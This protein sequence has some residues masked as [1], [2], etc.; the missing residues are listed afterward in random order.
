MPPQMIVARER[1]LD[2]LE[3][4]AQTDAAVRAN[5]ALARLGPAATVAALNHLA[6]IGAVD[7]FYLVAEGYY[8]NR[9][10]FGGVVG[11]T[12]SDPSITDQH[13]RITQLLFTPNM[14]CVRTDT[15]FARL[16]DEVGL[17]EYWTQ[18]GLEPDYRNASR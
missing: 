17:T 18:T 12:A 10:P 15:R 16:C 11:R 9:G 5:L 1:L 3:D 4:G 2:A 6:G 7:E 13:R 14:D 8:L